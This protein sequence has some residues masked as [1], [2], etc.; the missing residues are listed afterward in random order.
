VTWE[1]ILTT[2]KSGCWKDTIH[3]SIV[4]FGLA[5]FCLFEARVLEH[6]PQPAP[7]P[8]QLR[9]YSQKQSPGSMI[10]D[11]FKDHSFVPISCWSGSNWRN[12]PSHWLLCSAGIR[13]QPTVSD[14]LHHRK[15]IMN[16]T[17]FRQKILDYFISTISSR[18]YPHCEYRLCR[19]V[20]VHCVNSGTRA[21]N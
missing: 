3:M 21:L 16:S 20:L 12:L 13:V 11:F 17:N 1:W 19:S 14:F 6:D 15:V 7:P 9:R 2:W 4:Y 8:R 10:L 5:V 18:S